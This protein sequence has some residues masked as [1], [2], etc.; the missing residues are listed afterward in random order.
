MLYNPCV[1]AFMSSD[2]YVGR[3]LW[4]PEKALESLE[5]EF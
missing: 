1:F 2:M 3:S 5:L 4:R